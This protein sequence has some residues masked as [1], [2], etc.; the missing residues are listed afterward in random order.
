M[1]TNLD[2]YRIILERLKNE[3]RLRLIPPHRCSGDIIDLSGNDYLG[4]GV[5]SKEWRESFIRNC[6]DSFTSSASRLLAS[7]QNAYLDLEKRL[8]ELYQRPALLFNSG[9]H[10]NV[11]CINALNIPGTVFLCDKLIHASVIDGITMAHADY[12]RWRHNDMTHLR[13]LL[14]KYRDV[15]QRMIVVAESIYSMDGDRAPLEELAQ[16]KM[17]FPTMLLYLDEAH[18]FGVA[19]NQGLG[20]AEQRNLLNMPDILIGTFG[21]ACASV[22]AFCVSSPLLK[23]LFINTARTFIFSTAFPPVNARWTLEMLNRLVEMKE[24]RKRLAH[25]SEIFRNFISR[26]TGHPSPSMSQ[27]VPLITGDAE[28][29][30]KIAERLAQEGIDALAIR[31]PT[32][33][34]GGERIRFSLNASLSDS[35]LQHVMTIIEKIIAEV[36]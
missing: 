23:E 5:I 28:K 13:R 2:G 14:K 31:R 35:E 36:K 18:G 6:E 29:A 16:L 34:P 30:L 1:E 12:A 11:G 25:I 19:G 17:E 9:Y 8:E 15:S 7:E 20:C 33:P 3:H 26:I 32:V 22:G 4:L 10:A 27:I 21:K 24:E